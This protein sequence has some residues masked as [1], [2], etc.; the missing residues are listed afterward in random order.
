LNRGVEKNALTCKL[1]H[2]FRH[3][4]SKTFNIKGSPKKNKDDI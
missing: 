4:D 3:L 1:V 2:F